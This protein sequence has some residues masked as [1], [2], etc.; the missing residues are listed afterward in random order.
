MWG[1]LSQLIGELSHGSPATGAA[2]QAILTDH[3]AVT[4]PSAMPLA[5]PCIEWRRG[6]LA[7]LR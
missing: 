7:L 2:P 3:E 6:R 4:T 1:E 5:R